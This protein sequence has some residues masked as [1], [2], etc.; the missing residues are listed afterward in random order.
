MSFDTT[1]PT[2]LM[3]LRDPEDDTA[4]RAFAAQYRDLIIG[5]CVRCGLQSA[6]VDDVEQI[7]WLHLAKGLRSFEYDPEKGRFRDY[8]RKVVR[9]AIARRF[10]RPTRHERSLDTTL[11]AITQS[12]DDDTD[13]LWESEWVD[14]H[15]RLALK[16]IRKSFDARSVAIF[17]LLLSG[18]SIASVANKFD[19]TT[20]A[21]HKVKQ[22]IRDKMAAL[23]ERQIRD[24]DKPYL[25]PRADKP[26]DHPNA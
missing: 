15:Y 17:E 25:A 5:Y 20:Q 6:D 22:R 26:D 21:I 14:H 11:L 10:S 7:V 24:E 1:Q 16:S 3:R 2:L 8:L 13:R 4:W 18:D 12:K 23:I 9:H 19:T